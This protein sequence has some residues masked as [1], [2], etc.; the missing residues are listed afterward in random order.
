MFKFGAQNHTEIN[1]LEHVSFQK[2]TETLSKIPGMVGLL[3]DEGHG[4]TDRR[5]AAIGWSDIEVIGRGG[6]VKSRCI[7]R[8]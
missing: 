2:C 1:D 7:E 8:Q 4:A 3:A 6:N 5:S